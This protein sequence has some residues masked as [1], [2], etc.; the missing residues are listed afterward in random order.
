MTTIIKFLPEANQTSDVRKENLLPGIESRR[1]YFGA[2]EF[3]IFS[4]RGSFRTASQIGP[5]LSSPYVMPD[6]VLAEIASCSRA[7][8]FSPTQVQMSARFATIEGPS[9][10]SFETGRS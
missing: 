10:A 5:S 1:D 7:R 3:T 2:N 4:N 6:G 9:Q 8:S